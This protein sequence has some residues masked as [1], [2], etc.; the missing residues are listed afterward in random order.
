MPGAWGY[1]Y[2]DKIKCL[3]SIS[4]L[5]VCLCINDELFVGHATFKWHFSDFTSELQ[6]NRSLGR[7]FTVQ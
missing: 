7:Y 4:S 3:D 5:K 6:I 2:G 1:L